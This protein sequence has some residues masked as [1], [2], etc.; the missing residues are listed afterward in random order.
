VTLA[1][2]I[3]AQ[4]D[5]LGQILRFLAV[6]H[7]ADE[8]AEHASPVGGHQLRERTRLVPLNAEHEFDFRVGDDH[9]GSC[10]S[11]LGSSMR[12]R[13]PRR[14]AL[15][16]VSRPPSRSTY[17]FTIASPSPACTPA[18]LR[19]GSPRKNRS[20]ILSWISAGM[21]TPVSRTSS[22]TPPCAPGVALSS[23]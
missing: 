7:L 21:P 20:K 12:N 15:S 14:T 6:S 17:S 1:A 18:A 11:A 3:K 23:T 5:I 4:E 13:L 22:T 8:L 19:D 9:R 16:T 10:Y 2:A